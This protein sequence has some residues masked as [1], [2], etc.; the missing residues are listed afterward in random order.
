MNKMI[1]V[2]EFTPV[3]IDQ[4]FEEVKS[5]LADG[6]K[7]Y[8][9]E[10]TEENLPGAKKMA[11]E[12][13]SLSGV[14]GKLRKEKSKEMSA[15]I[16]DFEAKAKELEDMCQAG[17]QKILEQV[18]AFEDKT[19]ALCEELVV[20]LSTELYQEKSVRPEFQ[21]ATLDDLIKISNVTKTGQL[22]AQA[23]RDVAGKV[24][25]CLAQQLMRDGRLARLEADCLFAGLKTPLQEIHVRQILLKPDEEY[26]TIVS[27]LIR[28][29]VDKQK[30]AE[31]R[32][33]K[34]AEEKVRRE[35]QAR[36]RAEEEAK[37]K[38]ER[39]E[40]ARIEAEEKAK[41]AAKAK[42]EREESEKAEA[43]MR[44][45]L[46]SVSI[47]VEDAQVVSEKS[48]APSLTVVVAFTTSMF[49]SEEE[50]VEFLIACGIER[51]C[52][53]NIQVKVN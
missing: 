40:R 8:E 4:N 10:V 29:E 34:E 26:N 32:A 42:A 52:I 48:D 15:P 50:V 43:A 11:T 47:N 36:I 1:P 9:I 13:N 49:S 21:T 33:K 12:L 6:L 31:E 28:L 30:A 24:D 20:S 39:E 38:A 5:I 41:A 51:P 37:A 19:R 25:S 46:P 16:K 7:A 23:K 53:H 2:V 22:T 14:L 44:A 45:A 17:R 3:V 35:E 18:K 27:D